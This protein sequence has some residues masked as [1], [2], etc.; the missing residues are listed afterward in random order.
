VTAEHVTTPERPTRRGRLV[1]LVALVLVGAV[2]LAAAIVVRGRQA[3]AAPPAAEDCEKAK[4]KVEF[5]VAECE[6]GAAPAHGGATTP[7]KH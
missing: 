4:P 3:T 6:G 7:A 5:A 2:V 1:Y